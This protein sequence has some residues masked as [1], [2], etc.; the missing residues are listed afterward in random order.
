MLTVEEVERAFL[1][2]KD[3]RTHSDY[4]HFADLYRFYQHIDKARLVSPRFCSHA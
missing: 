2:F 1:F 3:I 4:V